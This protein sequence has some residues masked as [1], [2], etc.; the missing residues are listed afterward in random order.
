MIALTF[1]APVNSLHGGAGREREQDC[2]TFNVSATEHVNGREL[3]QLFFSTGEG[4]NEEHLNSTSDQV[5]VLVRLEPS[6]KRT[7]VAV[8]RFV[9][10]AEFAIFS[11]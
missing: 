4:G 8:G 3:A 2:Q 1:R 9:Y 7:Y 11:S 10:L 6:T 5:R